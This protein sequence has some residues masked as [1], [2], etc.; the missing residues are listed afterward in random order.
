[1]TDTKRRPNNKTI[2]KVIEYLES[3]GLSV[4]GQCADLDAGVLYQ[5]NMDYGADDVLKYI[6][7]K[8]WVNYDQ[9]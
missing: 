1:M 9:V 3:V 2:R 6:K 7:V 4:Y 5:S 8:D